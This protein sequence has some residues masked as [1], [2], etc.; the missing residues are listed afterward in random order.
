MAARLE[1]TA[2]DLSMGWW[3][4]FGADF[5]TFLAKGLDFKIAALKEVRLGLVDPLV[6]VRQ[7]APGISPEAQAEFARLIDGERQAADWFNATKP[8]GV[9][10]VQHVPINGPMAER[11]DSGDRLRYDVEIVVQPDPFSDPIFRRISI[12][13]PTGLTWSELQDAAYDEAMRRVAKSPK[14][15]LGVASVDA[16]IFGEANVIAIARAF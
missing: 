14:G 13:A 12:Y 5:V 7:R 8:S 11:M 9:W 16:P 3:T 10:N 15:F 2:G 6:A 1:S 4:Q